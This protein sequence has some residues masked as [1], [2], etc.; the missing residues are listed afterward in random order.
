MK[1]QDLVRRIKSWKSDD[2]F[3][4]GKGMTDQE[5]EMVAEK[6]LEWCSDALVGARITGWLYEIRKRDG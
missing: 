6:F 5:A 2:F 3:D 1:Y 4:N